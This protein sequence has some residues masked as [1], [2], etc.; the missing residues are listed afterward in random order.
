MQD[1]LLGVQQYGMHQMLYRADWQMEQMC[2]PQALRGI[3]AVI[4]GHEATNC[5][6]PQRAAG[7]YVGMA[8]RTSFRVSLQAASTFSQFR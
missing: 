3:A 5:L 4:G 6:T 8:L 7:A 2:S 1:K